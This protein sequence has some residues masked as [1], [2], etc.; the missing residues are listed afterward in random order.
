VPGPHR[1]KAFISYSHADRR[2]TEWLFRRI[3]SYAAPR[4]LVG[5]TG[6]WGEIERRLTPV[7][8][9]RDELSTAS[10]LGEVLTEAL[11]GSEFLIVVCSPKSANSRWVNEEIRTFRAFH[12]SERVLPVIVAGDPGAAVGPDLQGAFPPALLAP[13]GEDG[14]PL[15]PVAADLRGEGDGRRAGFLKLVAGMLGV[16][17]DDLVHRE[18][19]RRQRVMTRIAAASAA[20]MLVFAAI[21]AYAVLQRDEARRQ[22]AIAETERDTATSALD[23]LAGIFE[24]ANPATEN[25][26]TITAL[27]VLDRGRR[28]IETTFADKPAVQ[29]KLMGVMGRVYADLGEIETA[30]ETLRLAIEKP[31]APLEDRLNAQFRLADILT[32]SIRLDEA[33]VLL[34][35]AEADLAKAA[36]RGSSETLDLELY[37]GRLAERRADIALSS[38]RDEDAIALFATAKQ[39]FAGAR[40]DARVFIA[41]AASTRG[42]TL[43]RMK[44][45]EEA[46]EELELARTVQTERHGADH[47]ETA[48]AIHNLGYMHF[49]ARDLDRA[50][51]ELERAMAI[52]EKVLEPSHPTRSTAA[53]LL[54]RIQLAKGDGQEAMGTFID[55]VAAAKR[56]FGPTSENVG[57]A[58]LYLAHA[59][60]EAGA[61]GAGLESLDEAQTIYDA[62]FPAGDFNHGDIK[63]YRAIVLGK[64]GRLA[65]ARAA[66]ADG[67]A[68]LARN[69]SPDDA[70]LAE[71]S[72][73]CAQLEG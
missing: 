71:M 34:D 32:K 70:Y 11:K 50:G 14:T 9:D 20:G 5:T 19:K 36:A 42:I 44:R 72:A 17:L 54:G 69:L 40:S 28:R 39:H 53:L 64:A 55:V 29:A 61:S 15:E 1:Y 56:N 10:A 49:E 31:G 8:R 73:H 41:R 2:A 12:G 6:R 3:E 52:Y 58:L 18:A 16:G 66:C 63:V 67:L 65:E 62:R 21:A 51:A 37:R 22:R 25:P 7:F 68:T 48:I 38:A 45:F 27:T 59:Q 60:A 43:A 35:G 26:K 23:Y 30:K 4:S 47:L 33:G 13:D 46:R 24:I 57:Y